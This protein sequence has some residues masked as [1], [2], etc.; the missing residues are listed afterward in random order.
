MER[1]VDLAQLIDGLPDA[2]VVVRDGLIR[3]ANGSALGLVGY[4]PDELAGVALGDVLPDLAADPEASVPD[5]ALRPGAR[6]EGTARH[7]DGCEVP[8]E[9]TVVD[10][11]RRGTVALIL[12]DGAI[13]RSLVGQLVANT[14]LMTAMATGSPV[15]ETM[16]LAAHH[17]RSILQADACWVALTPQGAARLAVVARDE[18]P[19]TNAAPGIPTHA[20]AGVTDSGDSVDAGPLLVV[21]L[22]H[23]DLAGLIALARR[24][25]ARDFTD[26]DREIARQFAAVVAMALDLDLARRRAATADASAEYARIA[27]ELHDTVMQRLFAEGLLLETAAPLAPS[28][29]AERIHSAVCNLDDVIREIR[30]TIFEPSAGTRSNG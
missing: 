10:I 1:D 18:A 6:V 20:P 2:V 26:A 8:V 14:E 12:R 11:G 30:E 28:P 25:G 27:R 4:R 29:V 7:R 9:I 5:G 17:L 22:G 16:R 24:P 3:W 23:V 13:R 15:D 19:S 21:E